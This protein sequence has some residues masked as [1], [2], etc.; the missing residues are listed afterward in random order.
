MRGSTAKDLLD[1]A[2]AAA[3]GDTE[4]ALSILAHSLAAASEELDRRLDHISAGYVR[5]VLRTS[6]KEST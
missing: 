3:G 4:E 1:A 6:K 2:L 5:A